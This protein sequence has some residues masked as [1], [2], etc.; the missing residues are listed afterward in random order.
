ML[1]GDGIGS[2]LLILVLVVAWC[3]FVLFVGNF[4]DRCLML[5]VGLSMFIIGVVHQCRMDCWALIMGGEVSI[6][7]GLPQN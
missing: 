1:I 2:I 4:N 6:Q 7:K 3:W 5:D